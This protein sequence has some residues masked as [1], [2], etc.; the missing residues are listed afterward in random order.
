MALSAGNFVRLF[1]PW[2][3]ELVAELELG[4]FSYSLKFDPNGNWL[5][6]GSRDGLLR[7]WSVPAILGSVGNGGQTNIELGPQ[8]MLE[9]H[10]KGINSI[11]FSSDG[12]VL[13]SGGSDAVARF[14]DSASGESLGSV[15]GGTFVVPG[16]AF[17]PH[18][19][20]VAVVNGDI[21]RLRDINSESILGTFLAETSLYCLA[22]NP[23]GSWLAAGGTDNGIRLWEPSQAFRTGQ[24][25]YPDP[26]FLIGH[27]G[28]PGGYQA[29]IWQVLFSPDGRLLAS[30]GGDATVRFWDPINA[31]L[32]TTLANHNLAVTSLAF[33]PDGLALASGGLDSSVRIWGIIK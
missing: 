7:I 24:E 9:A 29:L 33:H 31:T 21:V 2:T 1:H 28:Q 10:K 18:Q 8:V 14:W 32:L 23:D 16:I 4:A 3:Q 13:A 26:I 30:A 19:D 25:S 15:I 22:F 27:D 11:A 20:T 6:A 5:A 12:R 17:M